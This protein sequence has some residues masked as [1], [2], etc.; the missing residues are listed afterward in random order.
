MILLALY[1]PYVFFSIVKRVSF[2]FLLFYWVFLFHFFIDHKVCLHIKYIKKLVIRMC[3]LDGRVGLWE[4]GYLYI[5]M[6]E[7]MGC[8]PETIT[9]L[10]IGYIPIQNKKLNNVHRKQ[11]GRINSSSSAIIIPTLRHQ[12]KWYKAIY[13]FCL[14]P[15]PDQFP[16]FPIL[17]CASGGWTLCTTSS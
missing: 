11:A 14:P 12:D 2:M 13:L 3:N 16:P 7:S 4:N 15:S 17:L 10:V 5:W 8:K 6:A 9:T 1:D